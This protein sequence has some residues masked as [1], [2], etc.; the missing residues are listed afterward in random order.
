MAGTMTAIAMIM[1]GSSVWTMKDGSPHTTGFWAEEFVKPHKTFTAAGFD[2]TL[3]TPYGKT[4]ATDPL[5]LAL[6]YN[7]FSRQRGRSRCC[8]WSTTCNGPIRSAGLRLPARAIRQA[9]RLD[10]SQPRAS[11]FA[12]NGNDP[13]ARPRYPAASPLTGVR[14]SLPFVFVSN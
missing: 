3:S 8:A 10:R 9:G 1:T 5:S 4:P 12:G 13:R 11:R 6:A 2:V 14:A 7:C